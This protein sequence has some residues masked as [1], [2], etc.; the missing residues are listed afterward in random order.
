MRPYFLMRQA[1]VW[2]R[3]P[4]C[5]AALLGFYVRHNCKRSC[6]VSMILLELVSISFRD[7]QMRASSLKRNNCGAFLPQI[8]VVTTFSSRWSVGSG[9]C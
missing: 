8:S 2:R 7:L 3:I 5:A 6:I 1:G 4:S 9:G